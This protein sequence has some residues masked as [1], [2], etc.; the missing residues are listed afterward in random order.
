MNPL[1]IVALAWVHAFA[2]F[3]MQSDKMAISKSSSNKWLLLHV[4]IY[5]L[6]LVPFGW[7]FALVNF[8]AH[9]CT[10]WVTSRATTKLW[11]AG[12]RHWF[13]VMIGA[14]Q[15]LHMTALVLTYWWLR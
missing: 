1:I 5:A 2:D 6:C 4:G 3:V 10:D 15:A 12:E 9:F 8:A 11:K 13:F 7:R 14:D